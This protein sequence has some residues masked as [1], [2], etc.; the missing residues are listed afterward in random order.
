M[1]HIPHC[2]SQTGQTDWTEGHTNTQKQTRENNL[3]SDWDLPKP[4]PNPN[5]KLEVDKINMEKLS[6]EHD[7]PQEEQIQIT[8]S[9]IPPPKTDEIEKTTIEE[10]TDARTR[11]QQEEEKY[12]LQ[13]KVYIG[14]LS[15]EES[16]TS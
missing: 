7:N 14:Q 3:L 1:F 10:K 9:L 2:M 12:K 4:Q 15:D 6:L 16:D 11:Y 8:D 5:S 13:Q